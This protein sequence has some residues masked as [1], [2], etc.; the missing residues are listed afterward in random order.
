MS[1]Y[2]HF[3]AEEQPFVDQ[4]VEWKELVNNRFIHKLTDFLDPR[5]QQIVTSVIGQDPDVRFSF[6]GGTG[7]AERKRAFL[8]PVYIEPTIE[9]YQLAAF[10]VHY[11]HKFIQLAHR[12]LL[13]AMMGLGLKRGK[14]GDIYIQ[15]EK[16]Q[17]VVASEISSY[18]EVNLQNVGRASIR[19]EDIALSKLLIPKEEWVEKTVAASSF[20]LD[21]ILS[22]IYQLSRSKIAPFIENKRVKVNWKTVE[23]PAFQLQNGDYLSVRGLGRSKVM[24]IQGK[25][26][27]DKW[28][29]SVGLLK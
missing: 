13:G 21:V 20:R 2:D 17:M 18:I 3:R 19:L 9:D 1:I 8:H 15:E 27:K 11:P 12:D 26:K 4:V 28:R 14:F 6:F 22:E 7:N 29:I 16:I 10:Q 24:A 23:Q 5:Q 25:T